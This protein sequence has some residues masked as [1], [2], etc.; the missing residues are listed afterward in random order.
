MKKHNSILLLL[1]LL[2][3]IVVAIKLF[4]SR[5]EVTVEIVKGSVTTKGIDIQITDNSKGIY[6]WSDQLFILMNLK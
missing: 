2:A 1:I 6:S 3:I 4:S 5:S